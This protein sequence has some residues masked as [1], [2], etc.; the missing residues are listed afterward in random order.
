VGGCDVTVGGRLVGASTTACG[1]VGD[2][3]MGGLS[4]ILTERLQPALAMTI[5][6][7]NR[8][9]FFTSIPPKVR[10]TLFHSNNLILGLKFNEK[11]SSRPN[12][13]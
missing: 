1:R 5:S 3:D 8:H 4:T 13:R 6:V 11:R 9:N 7:S 2:G 12:V 10:A